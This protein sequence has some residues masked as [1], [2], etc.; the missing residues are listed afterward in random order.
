M[1]KTRNLINL[2]AE[3]AFLLWREASRKTARLAEAADKADKLSRDLKEDFKQPGAK[4]KLDELVLTGILAAQLQGQANDAIR[5]LALT[6][7]NLERITAGGVA[8]DFSPPT[9]P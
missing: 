1:E 5:E 8:V 7:A 2:E 9:K 4:V 6:L 3:N